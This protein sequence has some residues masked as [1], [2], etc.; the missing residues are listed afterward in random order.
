MIFF[1][2]TL[3]PWVCPFRKSLDGTVSP[4]LILGD[5]LV[6][7]TSLGRPSWEEVIK[8]AAAAQQCLRELSSLSPN[9]HLLS[10]RVLNNTAH[11]TKSRTGFIWEV[12]LLGVWD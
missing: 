9:Q 11:T 10:L 12:E 6:V 3:E 4:H 1:I 8:K 2:I 5:S 7:S